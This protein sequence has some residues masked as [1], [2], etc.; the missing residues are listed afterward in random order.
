MKEAGVDTLL[1]EADDAHEVD[2]DDIVGCA[3]V[4][5]HVVTGVEDGASLAHGVSA[6]YG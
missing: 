2:V 1:R 3:C 5:E 4:D 6:T